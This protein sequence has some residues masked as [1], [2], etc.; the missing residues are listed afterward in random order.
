V[1][2]KQGYYTIKLG[3]ENRTLHFSMNFWVELTEHLGISLQELGEAFTDKM[4]LSGVRGIIYCGMLA[5]DK[6]NKKEITYTVYDVGN[7]LEELSQDDITK[8]M[9]VMTETKVLGNQLNAGIQRDQKKNP[10]KKN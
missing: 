3:G 7:W 6:E 1:N 4:A 8:I 2:K 5:N 9:N 10:I